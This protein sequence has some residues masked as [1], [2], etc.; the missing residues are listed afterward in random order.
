MHRVEPRTDPRHPER[1]AGHEDIESEALGKGSK[2]VPLKDRPGG[3]GAEPGWENGK[4]GAVPS[5]G[6]KASEPLVDEGG[7][8]QINNNNK[9]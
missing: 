8:R 3:P 6:V 2:H 9:K 1:H 5:D 7:S 4:P